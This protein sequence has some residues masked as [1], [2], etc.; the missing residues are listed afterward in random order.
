MIRF[1]IEAGT[2]V[3]DSIAQFRFVFSRAHGNHRHAMGECDANASIAAIGDVDIRY[4]V[5]P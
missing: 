5:I 3:R 4:G 1:E 2:A